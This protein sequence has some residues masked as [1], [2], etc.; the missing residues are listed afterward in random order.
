MKLHISTHE[1]VLT[2][3]IEEVINKKFAPKVSKF[4]TH[5]PDDSVHIDLLLAKGDRWGFKVSCEMDLPG[6]NIH[7]EASHKELAFA[8]TDLAKELHERLR[9]KKEKSLN[10]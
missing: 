7:A 4:L 6:E 1:V 8:I 2:P 9:K 3:D 10:N 5:Y